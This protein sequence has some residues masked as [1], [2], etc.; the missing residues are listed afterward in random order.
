[1]P[2]EADSPMLA[3]ASGY[4]GSAADV[5]FAETEADVVKV[6]RSASAAGTPVTIS[7][8]GT[9]LTGGRVP[10]GGWL[11]ALEKM[12]RLEVGEGYAL[13]GP[14]VIL[15]DLGAAAAA[16]KQFYAPDPTE[17]SASVGGTIATNASG[18]RSFLYGPTRRYVRALRVVLASGEVLV[19]RRGEKPPFDLPVVAPGG[20]KKSTAGYYLRRG[21]DYLDLFVGWFAKSSSRTR[22]GSPSGPSTTVFTP[23]LAKD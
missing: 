20:S 18:S 2:L 1:M 3:D 22:A 15:R 6:M 21:M 12:N 11:L 5:F 19:L 23:Y 13:C 14:G 4:R 17:Y 8:A 7:G 9:G 10:H 16:R